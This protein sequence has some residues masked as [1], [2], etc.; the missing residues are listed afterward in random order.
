MEFTTLGIC[1]T[2]LGDGEGD[3]VVGA[4][5]GV[6]FSTAAGFDSARCAFF[7][8]GGS[9]TRINRNQRPDATLTTIFLRVDQRPSHAS[10]MPAGG[11]S[12]S[13]VMHSAGCCHQRRGRDTVVA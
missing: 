12:T 1:G 8:S 5:D 7:S 11:K 10:K 3:A 6:A 4:A 2:G 9:D 13:S